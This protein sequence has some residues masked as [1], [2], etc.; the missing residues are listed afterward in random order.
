MARYSTVTSIYTMLPG[1]ATS[2]AYTNLITQHA[3]RVGGLIEGYVGRWYK[4]SSW[5]TSAATPQIIQQISDAKT[6]QL[7]MRSIFTKDGQNRNEWVNELAEQAQKDL[8]AI[9]SQKLMVFD[10]DGSESSR[11]ASASFVTATRKDYTP[12]FDMDKETGWGV[13]DDLLDKIDSERS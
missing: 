8:E 4:F 12:V 1:L 7:T 10:S 6:A 9:N 5:T 3:N 11:Q 2:T 13:D